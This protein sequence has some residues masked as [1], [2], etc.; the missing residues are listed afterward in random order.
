MTLEIDGATG[1]GGGQ[2][3][4]TAL[5]LSLVTGTPIRLVN[6]RARR[7][8]PGLLRQH[9]T[10]VEAAARVGRAEVEGARLHA[11]ALTFAPQAPAGGAYVFDIGTAGSTT[12][13]LQTLLPALLRADGPSSV[14]LRGGTHNPLAPPFEFVAHAFLPLLRRMGAA[15]E[16]RLVR[17][18]FFPAGGGEL[19]AEVTPGPLRPLDLPER[20]RVVA[21]RATALVANLP[22]HIAERELQVVAKRLGW[23]K[24]ELAV[25]EAEGVAGAGNVLTLLAEAEHGAEVVTGFGAK[26][27]PAEKVAEKACRAMRRWL[28]ARVPVGEHLADQL[29]V[30]LALAGGGRFRT[31]PPTAHATTNAALIER[32]LPVRFAWTAQ[33]DGA[34]LLEARC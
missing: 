7:A 12:L 10:A 27:T 1:E 3:V 21:R 14:V 30:P 15:V 28:D 17:P 31:L 4:R 16:V 29:L 5:S 9:L 33:E 34:L 20:G 18:G 19:A 22:R 8:R 25:A 6:I 23:K 24:A 11:T 13:V 26:G 32:F 2:I